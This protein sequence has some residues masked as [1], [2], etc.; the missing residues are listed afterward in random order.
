M[1]QLVLDIRPDAPPTLDNFVVGGNEELV[2][3]LGA[4]AAPIA[5]RLADAGHTHRASLLAMLFA[6]LSACGTAGGG[7]SS[8]LFGGG[9][10]S[11]QPAVAAPATAGRWL[12]LAD[13]QG[14]GKAL[15]AHRV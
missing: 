4:I 12:L 11:A 13:Q 10:A 8:G 9:A 3:T 1:K 7:A 15:A 5:G 6:S 14:V 2:A